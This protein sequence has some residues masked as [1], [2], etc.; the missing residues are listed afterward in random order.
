MWPREPYPFT[1][2]NEAE[3]ALILK[4]RLT[5][6]EQ[7]LRNSIYRARGNAKFL[8]KV[9]RGSRGAVYAECRAEALRALHANRIDCRVAAWTLRL[10][11]KDQRA[12]LA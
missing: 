6:T 12:A 8:V 10:K 7:D 2:K 1:P 4:K 9:I 3:T 5:L 11:R